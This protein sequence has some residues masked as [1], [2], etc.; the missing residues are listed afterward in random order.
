MKNDKTGVLT[1]FAVPFE[2]GAWISLWTKNGY[3]KFLYADIVYIKAAGSYSDFYLRNGEVVTVSYRL[4]CVEREL[5]GEYFV[6]THASFILN[7]CYIDLLSGN[8]LR[9]GGDWFPLGRAYRK[10][11]MARLNILTSRQKDEGVGL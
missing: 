5:A 1:S 10:K 11:V 2:V 4:A 8:S 3:E 9:I 6:R 7:I